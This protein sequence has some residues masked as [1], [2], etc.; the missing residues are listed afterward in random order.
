[1]TD[2][3]KKRLEFLL[4]AASKNEYVQ[5]GQGDIILL[6]LLAAKAEWAE[7]KGY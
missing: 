5:L 6:E 7:G 3:E 1:M 4:K 2:F